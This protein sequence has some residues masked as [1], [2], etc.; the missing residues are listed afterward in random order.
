MIKHYNFNGISP[1][2]FIAHPLDGV[3]AWV[4]LAP[5]LGSLKKIEQKLESGKL[6]DK[7]SAGVDWMTNP[8]LRYNIAKHRGFLEKARSDK[9]DTIL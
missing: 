1:M 7:I 5:E 9:D 2:S 6:T 3:A 4:D 8:S